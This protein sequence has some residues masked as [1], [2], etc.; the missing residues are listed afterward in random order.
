M[1]T[2]FKILLD[3]GGVVFLPSDAVHPQVKWPIIHQLNAKYG[4]DLNLGADVFP[5]F[6]RAYNAL[7]HQQISGEQF[8]D[9]VFQSVEFN[10]EL[11][12]ILKPLGDIII[13]SDNYKENILYMEKHFGIAEWSVAQQYSYDFGLFK[14]DPTFFKR[15]F[16][17]IPSLE[18][19]KLIFIDDGLNNIESAAI[20]GITGIQYKDNETCKQQLRALGIGLD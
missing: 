20:H 3:L 6:M 2:P 18:S 15:L 14:S 10:E 1:N 12:E 16:E 11:L 9:Q 7:T 17:E 8:L 5:E 4:K 19:Q 13:V